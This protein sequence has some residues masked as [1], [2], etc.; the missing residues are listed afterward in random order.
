MIDQTLQKQ[1]GKR[2]LWHPHK[3][4]VGGGFLKFFTSLQIPLS[5]N[6]I[7][8]HSADVES[9][10]GIR[11]TFKKRLDFQRSFSKNQNR[12]RIWFLFWL[13]HMANVA[14]WYKTDANLR[15]GLQSYI[16]AKHIVQPWGMHC[17]RLFW[18]IF[19]SWYTSS[20][21]KIS[22]ATSYTRNQA[23]E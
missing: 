19:E 5:L 17:T 6:N 3:R 1:K 10:V 22:K 21:Q 20:H 7:L 4:F 16:Y 11:R 14:L 15:H 2:H 9:W 12:I 23:I 13:I 8:V 18:N